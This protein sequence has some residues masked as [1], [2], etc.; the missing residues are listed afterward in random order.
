M[1]SETDSVTGRFAAFPSII[2]RTF[3]DEPK[4][5]Y[6][7]GIQ[8]NERYVNVKRELSSDT[9]LG[10]P[11]V[12]AFDYNVDDYAR[13]V[14]AFVNEEGLRTIY[15][16]LRAR[17]KRFKATLQALKEEV[18]ERPH[19]DYIFDGMNCCKVCG[20]VRPH[21]GWVRPCK[22]PVKWIE[23]RGRRSSG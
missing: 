5:L 23:G 22:G 12:D 3:S 21:D 17:P 20:L 14:E 18:A 7:I 9:Y 15:D 19:V 1:D 16:E 4:V 8:D 2:V 6:A 10:W 13:L 11:L